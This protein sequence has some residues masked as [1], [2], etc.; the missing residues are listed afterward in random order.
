MHYSQVLQPEEVNYFMKQGFSEN[1]IQDAVNQT[2]PSTLSQTYQQS[3]IS[4]QNDP[5]A[6]SSQSMFASSPHDNLIKWQLELDSILQNVEHTLRGDKVTYVDGSIVWIPQKDPDKR[7]LNDYGVSKVMEILLMYLNRNTILSNYEEQEIRQ[8]VYDFGN[9]L[10]DLFY[11][12][13]EK[14]GLVVYDKDGK[15]NE[16]KSLEKRKIYPMLIRVLVDVVHSA[17]LRALHGEER[18]SLT[19][20][21]T[22]QQSENMSGMGTNINLSGGMVRGE[23]GLLNPMRYIAGRYK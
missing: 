14:M 17:Y 8:K 19:T 10:K 6:R 4:K 1:E 3:Q 20:S 5:R 12:Q 11:T 2:E 16:R 7:Q 13:Y 9:E 15:V 23:R 22:V 21:R 18:K